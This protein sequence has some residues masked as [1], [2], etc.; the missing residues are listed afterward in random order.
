MKVVVFG[1]QQIAVDFINFLRKKNVTI[2]LIVTYELPLDKTYGYESVIEKFHDSGI[3]VLNPNRVNLNLIN[4]IEWQIY[5][6]RFP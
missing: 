5:H 1:C 2:S 6:S 4:E 3:K